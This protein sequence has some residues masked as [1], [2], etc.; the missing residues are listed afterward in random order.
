[1]RCLALAQ[2]WQELGGHCAFAIAQATPP[3]SAR[4][5]GEGMAVI[6]LRATP[7][8][9]EDAARTVELAVEIGASWIVVDGY[10]FSQSYQQRV[11]QAGFCLLLI[12]D[13]GFGNRY[14]ADAILNQNIYAEP[15]LYAHAE[16]T[17]HLLLGTKYALLRREFLVWQKWQRKNP[18]VAC[19]LLVTMGGSDPG[20]ATR[21]VIQALNALGRSDLET[22]VV[23]GPANRNPDVIHGPETAGTNGLQIVNDVP[24][25][26]ELMAWADL[27]VSAAGTTCWELAFFG[28]PAIVI[29]LAENQVGIAAG[30]DAAGVAQNM[31]SQA[32]LSSDRL[33]DRLSILLDDFGRRQRMSLRGRELVDGLGARRVIASMGN[34]EV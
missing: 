18:R 14:F 2:S 12:D 29:T 21:L 30:L 16:P 7:G 31:G 9:L 26:A 24:N 32:N 8:S 6:D 27:A 1:M 33:A 4:L 25:M 23:L 20:N 15:Q 17:T 10:H 28:L 19:K 3:L 13:M 22:R 5:I 34:R 11:R